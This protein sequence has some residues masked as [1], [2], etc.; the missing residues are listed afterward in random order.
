MKITLILVLTHTACY[1]LGVLI[2]H[3]VKKFDISQIAVGD[4]VVQISHV[5]YI[6]EQMGYDK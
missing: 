6:Q 4:D 3:L 5:G 2:G 1:F